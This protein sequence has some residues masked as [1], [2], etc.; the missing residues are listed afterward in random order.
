MTE[1]LKPCPFCGGHNTTQVSHYRECL[2]CETFGPSADGQFDR[3]NARP[4]EDALRSRIKE[5]EDERD[6]LK[7]R[8]K[9]LESNLRDTLCV[10]EKLTASPTLNSG[11]EGKSK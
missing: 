6:A 2:D 11:K 10:I 5:L 3:W 1:E 8:T 7:E 9:G 4:I